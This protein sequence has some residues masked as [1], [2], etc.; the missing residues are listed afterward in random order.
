M[1]INFAT[2]SVENCNR[3]SHTWK[4][5]TITHI[6]FMFLNTFCI[7]N[8]LVQRCA[9]VCNSNSAKK[10]LSSA[11]GNVFQ[12]SPLWRNEFYCGVINWSFMEQ[13]FIIPCYGVWF[14]FLCIIYVFSY[15]FNLCQKWYF[16][17]YKK[18]IKNKP[19]SLICIKFWI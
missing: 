19:S 12:W 7:H 9:H 10:R 14:N 11:N 4:P 5:A 6:E 17:V 2:K 18:K 1:S 16:V 15:F 13:E 3:T 8:A